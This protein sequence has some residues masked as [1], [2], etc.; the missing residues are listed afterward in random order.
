MWLFNLLKSVTY[1]NIVSP[2]LPN[3]LIFEKKITNCRGKYKINIVVLHIFCELSQSYSTSFTVPP[4]VAFGQLYMIPGIQRSQL[5]TICNEVS[6]CHT[7]MRL[8]PRQKLMMVCIPCSSKELNVITHADS[9]HLFP[10]QP[11]C[12]GLASL[13]LALPGKRVL[14][15]VRRGRD[16]YLRVANSGNG[17]DGEGIFESL[18]DVCSFAWYLIAA[19]ASKNHFMGSSGMFVFEDPQHRVFAALAK[20]GYSR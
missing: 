11:L 18:Q 14:E 19:S 17:D 12:N 8:T 20:H 15:T 2:S 13:E 3:L 16:A 4:S 1:A 9:L 5:C 6:T 7:T 10:I